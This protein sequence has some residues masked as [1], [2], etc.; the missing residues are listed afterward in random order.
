[1]TRLS[2]GTIVFD[3]VIL[4]LKFDLLLKNFNHGFYLVMVAARRASLSS[5]NSYCEQ[6]MYLVVNEWE[7]DLSLWKREKMWKN[8]EEDSSICTTRAVRSYFQIKFGYFCYAPAIKWLGYIVLPLS[9][10][11]SFRPS[12]FSFG[13]LSKSYMEIFKWNLVHRF[14]IGFSREYIGWVQI[15]VRWN[16]FRQSYAPWTEKNSINFQFPLIISITNSHFELKFGI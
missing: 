8:T 4:T 9:V 11:P 5:D 6:S 14:D 10:I 15:W 1:M 7:F 12:W 2:H 3:L 13:S 16:N